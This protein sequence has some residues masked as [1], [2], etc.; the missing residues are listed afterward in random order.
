VVVKLTRVVLLAPLV[1][2]VSLARRRHGQAVSAGGTRRPPVLPLFVAGFL[3]AVV[4]R[5]TGV[6][7]TSWLGDVKAL[8]KVLL[9]AALFGLGTGVQL[10]KLRRIGGRPLILGLG[11]WAL[12]AVV[13]Y[14]GVLV[15]GV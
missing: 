7:P 6:V 3:A 11:A 2:G 10:S 15:I 1:A 8:E 5:S 9:S 12:V 14:G 13:A 4:I